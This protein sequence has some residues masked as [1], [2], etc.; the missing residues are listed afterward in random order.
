MN[1]KIMK[2]LL[3]LLLSIS[4]AFAADITPE[5]GRVSARCFIVPVYQTYQIP[6][7]RKNGVTIV[8]EREV[9]VTKTQICSPAFENPAQ[10][11]K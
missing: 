9:F 4:S 7:F 6:L 3:I 10:I 11:K 8:E 5:S 2:T 1:N